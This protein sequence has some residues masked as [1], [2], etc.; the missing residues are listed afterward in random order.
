VID[1]KLVESKI[2]DKDSEAN[3]LNSKLLEAKDAE[4]L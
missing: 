2:M 3:M 4:K 1:I